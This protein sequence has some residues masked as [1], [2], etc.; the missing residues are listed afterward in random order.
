M[1]RLSEMFNVNHFIVSQVNPHVVPFLAKEEEIIAAEVQNHTAYTHRPSFMSLSANVA[2]GELLHRLQQVVDLG[3]L[4]NWFTKVKSILS[5]RYSGDI[6]I[7]PKISYADFPR[8]LSNPT[9]EYMVGCMLTGQRATWPKLSRVQN[10]VAIELALDSTIQKVKARAVFRLSEVDRGLRPSSQ[11]H[12]LSHKH[13]TKSVHKM[14]R[15]DIRTEPSSPVWRKSA[16][17]SPLLSRATPRIVFQPV[18][19]PNPAHETTVSRSRS[20]QSDNADVTLFDIMSSSNDTSDRDYFADPDSDTTD[21]ISSPSP[22]TSPSIQ[23][24]TL[25]P[26]PRQTLFPVI[27]QP[28]TP[29]VTTASDRRTGELLNLTMTSTTSDTPSEQE[30]RYKSMFHPAGPV[31]PDPNHSSSV[32]NGYEAPVLPYSERS[33]SRRGSEQSA[34]LGAMFDQSGTKGMLLR[35]L[36]S[37]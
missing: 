24:P 12:D 4:P 33:R 7:F 6:N 10:H 32:S 27:S 21:I 36:S 16:P 15:V 29:A 23:G 20:S 30:L 5:Q 26:A 18:S 1:T 34:G 28:P 2:K 31:M 11:G 17:T 14:T 25:W 3:V 19:P 37:K 8:V 13:R 9:P 35:R 22:P